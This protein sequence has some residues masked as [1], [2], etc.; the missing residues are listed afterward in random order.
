MPADRARFLAPNGSP[1][2]TSS[3]SE[4]A[5]VGVEAVGPVAVA[6]AYEVVADRL[7]RAIQLG[8]LTEGDRLPPERELAA[9]LG[10]SRVTVRE[11]LSTLQGGG[12]IMRRRGGTNGTAITVPVV[13]E[14][15]M[16]AQLRERLPEI[17][18]VCHFRA[19]V[20]GGAAEMAAGRRTPEALAALQAAVAELKRVDAVP[21]FRRADAMFHLQIARMAANAHF[22]RAIVDARASMF[23][24]IDV[25][26]YEPM[27]ERTIASHSAISDAIAEGDGP[28]A[29]ELMVVHV[30]ESHAELVQVLAS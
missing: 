3:A 1:V 2:S 29:A 17:E 26:P 4:R 15:V 18:D 19:I 12:W 10:V 30:R 16:R 27:V 25:L 9:M 13:D 21:G 7:C 6:S 8:L 11:A 28:R 14:N 5:L 23:A 20:E 22:E 24:P